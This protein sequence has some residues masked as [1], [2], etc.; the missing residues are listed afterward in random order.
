MGYR[1]PTSKGKKK[2]SALGGLFGSYPTPPAKKK[3]A[4]NGWGRGLNPAQRE[5]IRKDTWKR[6]HQKL[7]AQFTEAEA[8]RAVELALAKERLRKERLRKQK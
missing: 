2:G 1:D 3:P 8:R 6:L 4:Q 7:G 5:K